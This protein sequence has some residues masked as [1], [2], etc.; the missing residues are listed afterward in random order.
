MGIKLVKIRFKGFATNSSS[1]HSVIMAGTS[2][3]NIG[4]LDGDFGWDTFLQSTKDEKLRYLAQ[5]LFDCLSGYDEYDNGKK[6]RAAKIVKELLGVRCLTDLNGIDHQSA[7]TIPK[8]VSGEIALDFWKELS[9][10]LS[11]DQTAEILGGN[12]G[13]EDD[14]IAHPFWNNLRN[15]LNSCRSIYKVRKDGQFWTLFNIYDG[16]KVVI[17]LTDTEYVDGF[18]PSRPDLVDLKIT[19]CCDVGCTFC[20]QDSKPNGKHATFNNISNIVKAMSEAEVFEIAIGG[21]EPT[22]HPEF[23]KILNEIKRHG[24]VANFS[25]KNY[26]YFTDT[27]LNQLYSKIG[28]VGISVSSVADAEQ[29]M[30]IITRRAQVNTSGM[31]FV[32]RIMMHYILD[33]HPMSN[34]VEILNVLGRAKGI[35]HHILLLGKKSG[36]RS[37]GNIIDNTGWSILLNEYIKRNDLQ[38]DVSV[39]TLIVNRYPH[40][41]KSI[42]RAYYYNEEGRFSVYVNAVNKQFGKASYGTGLYKYKSPKDILK[43]FKEWKPERIS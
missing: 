35:D 18:K 9:Q 24:M 5:A 4:P 17:S 31:P 27:N 22:L 23:I 19:N 43:A 34:L 10:A 25:S 30:D 32:T 12:D 14:G 2:I 39:D 20:Y 37:D 13:D 8:R 11:D 38:L 1:S 36:G 15:R 26:K 41:L 21:G 29:Y 40:D 42:N 3:N 28:A 7:I 33:Q 6:N 16:E